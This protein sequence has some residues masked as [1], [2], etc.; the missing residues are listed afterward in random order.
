M[1]SFLTT[2]FLILL[3]LLTLWGLSDVLYRLYKKDPTVKTYWLFVILLFPLLGTIL[4]FHFK[5]AQR[6]QT[7]PFSQRI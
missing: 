6:S 1:E 7:R 2:I 4:Y 3:S 5:H